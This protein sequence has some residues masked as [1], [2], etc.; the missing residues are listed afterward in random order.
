MVAAD[1]RNGV[2]LRKGWTDASALS[3]E[4]LLARTEG[5]PLAGVL[6]TDVTREG[7]MEGIDVKEAARA[8]AASAHATWISGGIASLVEL[9]VLEAVGAAG[10]VLGMALYTGKLDAAGVAARYGVP[11]NLQGEAHGR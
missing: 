1:V 10:A 11:A 8:V 3:I 4:E 9:E 5:L 7:R 6:C 2:V